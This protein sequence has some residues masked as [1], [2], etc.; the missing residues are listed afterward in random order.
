M[1]A[2]SESND[3]ECSTTSNYKSFKMGGSYDVRKGL[4][5]PSLPLG[6][7][8]SAKAKATK[9]STSA[10]EIESA[11]KQKIGVHSGV[12][13]S[14]DQLQTEFDTRQCSTTTA[15]NTS[16]ATTTNATLQSNTECLGHIPL[17]TNGTRNE[18]KND[19]CSPSMHGERNMPPAAN[20]QPTP[21]L[22]LR[23]H[24]SSESG[25]SDVDTQAD[26]FSQFGDEPLNSEPTESNN[27]VEEHDQDEQH[28]SPNNAEDG[29]ETGDFQCSRC[30]NEFSDYI[31]YTAHISDCQGAKRRYRCIHPGCDREYAQRSIMLQ[32]HRSVHEQKPYLCTENN[33]HHRYTS[34]KA[35]KAHI[36]EHHKSIYKY[37]CQVCRQRFLNRSQYNI[38]LTRHTNLK[39]FGC[40]N[41]KKVAYT[42]AAQL[43]Q[44]VSMCL[45][46]SQY[47]CDICGKNFATQITLKQHITNI[48][49]EQGDF[50]CDLCPKVYKQYASLY[51]HRIQKHGN[52]GFS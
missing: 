31:R 12:N 51:K 10:T 44:H 26:L 5:D 18:T 36:R 22:S 3:A 46:G 20:L 4:P 13:N 30:F 32:H 49:R 23:Q 16:R 21:I 48:H 43:N 47:R 40:M 8:S 33:C 6:P 2:N 25:D 11:E 39:P 41:C 38:H 15:S 19:H 37:Q 42:T 29:Q 34:Q 9:S 24:L 7:I 17:P 50:R 45:F 14:S 1:T 52:L 28:S 35:L 27:I